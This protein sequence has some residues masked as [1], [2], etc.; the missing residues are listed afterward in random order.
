M[1]A[2]LERVLDAEQLRHFRERLGDCDWVDGNATSGPISAKAKHNLQAP[3]ASAAT[4]ELGGTILDRLGRHPAFLSAALPLKV[5][6]PLFNRY[7]VGMGFGD[8]VDN[9]IRQTS[10][11]RRYRTDLSCTL[12][13]SDPADYD[14]GELVVTG[15]FGQQSVKLAAGDAVLYPASSVH[16]VTPITRGRRL[17][18]FF[19][20]Q[21]MVRDDGQR[22]LLY[23]LDQAI[24]GAR[25]TLGDGHPSLA[26]LTSTYHNLIRMWADA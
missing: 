4:N 17:A 14:G 9:A 15:V 7:D 11:G 23:E 20:V 22:T 6:P 5:I 26:G 3:D 19:W 12:F 21:S 8:H 1:L 13:L 24:I 25:A 18:A 16:H 10:D 2:K